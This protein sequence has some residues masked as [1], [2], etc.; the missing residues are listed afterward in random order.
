MDPFCG[1]VVLFHSLQNSHKMSADLCLPKASLLA[2]T[3]AW[4]RT[5]PLRSFHF[6]ASSQYGTIAEN[7]TSTP[8]FLD[9]TP[10]NTC[11]DQM[12]S[13]WREQATRDIQNWKG[14]GRLQVSGV[15]GRKSK[16]RCLKTGSMS[17][18]ACQK[19]IFELKW[20]RETD[21][22]QEKRGS[23]LRNIQAWR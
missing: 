1:E 8:Y 5:V 14:A 6:A 7:R 15:I 16:V 20:N 17:W 4:L 23:W 13:R 22:D 2:S 11:L 9:N 18:T 12:D 3:A 10:L 19:L 21:R